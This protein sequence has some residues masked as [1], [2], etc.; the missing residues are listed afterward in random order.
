[1]RAN[2]GNRRRMGAWRRLAVLAGAAMI[3]TS[4]VGASTVTAANTRLAF[5]GSPPVPTTAPDPTATGLLTFTPVTAGGATKV[6]YAVHSYDNQNLTHVFLNLPSATVPQAAGLTVATVYGADAG[7]CTWTAGG[8][9]VSCDFGKLTPRK[10]DRAITVVWNVAAT[11]DT[12]QVPVFTASLQV[13]EE[14]NPNGTNVQVYQANSGTAQVEPGSAN[15]VDTFIPPGQAKQTISTSALGEVDAG[16]LS[17]AITVPAN[18]S[19][20]VHLKDLNT[21]TDPFVCPAGYVCQSD[22][23]IAAIPSFSGPY[24][25][26]TLTA[27]VPSTYRLQQAFVAHY[28]DDGSL[29]VLLLNKQK[30]ACKTANTVPC[31]TFSQTGNVVTI[32]VRTKSNGGMR[33]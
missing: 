5:V 21:S 8:T 20:T 7:S 23:S 14:T 30:D 17:T 9:T 10:P 22:Y 1:M 19:G 28:F 33:F 12:A 16:S 24:L 29:D 18:Q 25:E 32:Y 26:W 31:A 2:E 27:I 11:F 6:D 3:V 15:L 13:N 4:M